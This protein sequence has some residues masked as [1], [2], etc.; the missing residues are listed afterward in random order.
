MRLLLTAGFDRA[1]HAVAVA[2][3]ARRAGHDVATI[4]VVTPLRASRVRERIRKR[5]VASLFDAARRMSGASRRT[6][7]ASIESFLV[8][9]GIEQRSLSAWARAHGAKRHSVVD[10]NHAKSVALAM[11]ARADATLYAGGGILRAPFLDA[12]GGRVLN[13]H[14]GPL[15]H[16]R[17]MNACEW[18]LLLGHAPEVTI[19]WI[20]SGI[21][22]GQVVEAHPV[23]VERGDDIEAL[24]AKCT[25]IGVVGLVLALDDLQAP[26]PKRETRQIASRQCFMLAP[27]LRELLEKRLE[28]GECL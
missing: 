26:L 12:A 28:D 18:S 22:T 17:G 5:G 2:E 24:R 9:N 7:D 8:E 25:V 10:L 15:P 3:L 19:H 16:V 20:D 14:S 4:L 27:V 6:S 11:Q 13:A 1:L 21:D 23:P